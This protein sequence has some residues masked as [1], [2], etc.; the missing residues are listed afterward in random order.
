MEILP[1][2]QEG[3]ESGLYFTASPGLCFTRFTNPVSDW[4]IKYSSRANRN[5]PKLKDNKN[6][7]S[8]KKLFC[9]SV[10]FTKGNHHHRI[11]LWL[12]TYTPRERLCRGTALAPWLLPA[13]WLVAARRLAQVGRYRKVPPGLRTSRTPEGAHNHTDCSTCSLMIW[14]VK[15]WC[16]GFPRPCGHS[17]RAK[18]LY[19]RVKL[20]ILLL[21]KPLMVLDRRKKPGFVYWKESLSKLWNMDW[22]LTDVKEFP[23]EFI[24]TG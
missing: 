17:H 4:L 16:R 23:S 19:W 20:C 7:G 24:L 14:S 18:N 8:K 10:P 1:R 2:A 9:Y 12:Y 3:F 11:Y 22:M 5:S 13:G 6:S 21:R 15:A